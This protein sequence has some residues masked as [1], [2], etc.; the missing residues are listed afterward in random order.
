MISLF[1]L[2]GFHLLDSNART[3]FKKSL[4]QTCPSVIFADKKISTKQFLF[5]CREYGL[6]IFF[7]G[8]LRYLALPTTINTNIHY[9]CKKSKLSTTRGSTHVYTFIL[10]KSFEGLFIVINNFGL[11]VF[12]AINKSK[13][14]DRGGFSIFDYISCVYSAS[15]AKFSL[16]TRNKA[17]TGSAAILYK[18]T[19]K[20]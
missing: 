13:E 6:F 11:F 12:I 4:F 16:F 17:S 7:V 20:H 10:R 9:W 19:N 2:S 5:F 3:C 15:T 1:F 8:N 14:Q 18:S